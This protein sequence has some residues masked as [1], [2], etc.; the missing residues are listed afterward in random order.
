MLRLEDYAYD[1]PQEQIAQEP[2][3]RRDA[4]RLLVLDRTTGEVG[5]RRFVD[6]PDLLHPVPIG[7]A[8]G[9]LVGKPIGILLF[10]WLSVRARLCQIPANVSWSQLFGMSLLCG[11]GFTMSLFVASLA[12]ATGAPVHAGLERAGILMGTVAAGILGYI[13]LRL[14]P[15][16]GSPATR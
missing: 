1:L 6:L 10:T 14:L 13:W 12:F 8:L 15:D 4:S 5:H 11:V 7:I 9:L 16:T 2:A 3:D